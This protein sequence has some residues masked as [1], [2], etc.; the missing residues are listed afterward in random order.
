MFNTRDQLKLMHDS[1]FLNLQFSAN[2]DVKIETY[3][4]IYR[5]HFYVPTITPTNGKTLTLF[6][7]IKATY[8]SFVHFDGSKLELAT[9]KKLMLINCCGTWTKSN[10]RK[11]RYTLRLEMEK[12]V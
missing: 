7:D 12:M 9:G 6:F 10:G 2:N 4:G 11:I 3:D 5:E 1:S 8:S